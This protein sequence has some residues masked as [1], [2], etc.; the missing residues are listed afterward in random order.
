MKKG[1]IILIVVCAILVIIG[2]FLMPNIYRFASNLSLKND[3]VKVEKKEEKEE[4]T[5]EKKEVTL[6]SEILKE[7][8]YPVMHNDVT[9]KDTYYSL[10]KITISD[11]TNNDLLYNSFLQVYSG[12]LVK[13]GSVGCATTSVSVDSDYI[14]SRLQNIY[15]PNTG[16]ELTDFVV[17]SGSGS[18]YVG[19]FKY[20]TVSSKYIY[21]GNCNPVVSN[22]QYY[23]VKSIYDVST[24][25]DGNEIITYYN[26]AFL[27][28]EG[29]KYSLYSDVNYTNEISTGSN[30]SIADISKMLEKF[31]TK[32]YQ[33]T[34]SKERCNYDSYCFYE[35][36]WIDG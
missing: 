25:K 6:E 13:G 29:N 8:V 2:L 10:D 4:K 24:S 26:V 9:L 15:G 20:D 30:K 3:E 28:I 7:L 27:K 17:P 32:K 34:F 21:Y 19:T 1:N 35:G 11:F 16:Y 31:N 36:K 14:V 22:V 33:Y 12:Y 18:E 5:E 23:D